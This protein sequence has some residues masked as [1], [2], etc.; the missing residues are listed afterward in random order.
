MMG[1]QV[2]LPAGDNPKPNNASMQCKKIATSGADVIFC[3]RYE[4]FEE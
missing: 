3:P 4:V 1:L 2:Q